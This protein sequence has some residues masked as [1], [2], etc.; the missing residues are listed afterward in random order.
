MKPILF[1]G[2]ILQLIKVI[3]VIRV[4]IEIWSNKKIPI[5]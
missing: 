1:I 4:S 3:I 5:I 2:I